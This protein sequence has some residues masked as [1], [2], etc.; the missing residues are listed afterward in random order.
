[1]QIWVVLILSHLVYALRERIALVADC[2]PV[3]VSVP[4]LVDLL[5]RLGSSSWL[6]LDQLVQSGRQSG[7]L[8]ASPRLVL[9]VPQVE[10]S[11]YQQ[12]PPDLPRQRPGRAPSAPRKRAPKPATRMCGYQVQRQRRQADPSSPSQNSSAANGSH[13]IHF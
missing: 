2:D 9:A 6:Q 1:V 13:L 5:P 12:A 11:C 10:L 7:L 8:R 4:L 3:E